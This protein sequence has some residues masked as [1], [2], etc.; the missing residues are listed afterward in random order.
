[1]RKCPLPWKGLHKKITYIPLILLK[2]IQERL[3]GAARD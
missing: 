3:S 2:N 1:M